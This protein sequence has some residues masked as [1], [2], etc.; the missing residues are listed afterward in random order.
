MGGT[1]VSIKPFFVLAFIIS[2]VFVPVLAATWAE[3]N[4]AKCKNVTVALTF[5]ANE[6]LYLNVTYDSDMLAAMNDL[7]FYDEPCNEGGNELSYD[8]ESI[9][10]SAYGE[11]HI[12]LPSGISPGDII[13][14]Y[15]GYASAGDNTD[16]AD[17]WSNAH[18][19]YYF[20][21][22]SGTNIEDHS[23]NGNNGTLTT[24]G[25]V[26]MASA[27][28]IGKSLNLEPGSYVSIP[29][30][31][32]R[33]D[34]D[35]AVLYFVNLETAGLSQDI[36][37]SCYG[38]SATGR[39]QLTID[40]TNHHDSGVFA[41]TG[42]AGWNR[43]STITH[44]ANNWYQESMYVNSTGN[45]GFL[46]TTQIAL[47]GG[48]ATNTS[49]FSSISSSQVTYINRLWY[50]NSY[51]SRGDF[52]IDSFRIYNSP[53]TA[54]FVNATNLN[55]YNHNTYITFGAEENRPTAI[56]I[57]NIAFPTNSTYYLASINPQY[58]ATSNNNVTFPCYLFLDS[59]LQ[60]TQTATNATL[61]TG[62]SIT[63]QHGQHNFTTTCT[64]S[65][66]NFTSSVIFTTLD[67]RVISETYQ[68]TVY[69]TNSSLF[70][71]QYNTSSRVANI[72]A[73]FSYDDQIDTYY[74][75]PNYSNSSGLWNYNITYT[76][77]VTRMA[78]NTNNSFVW[79]YDVYYTNGTVY[80]DVLGDIHNQTVY[81]AYYLSSVPLS[82]YS[83]LEGDSFTT[84]ATITK[85][86]NNAAFEGWFD[87]D[88]TNTTGTFTTNSSS[89]AIFSKT[90]TAPEVDTLTNYTLLTYANA[91][92]GGITALRSYPQITTMIYPL[93]ITDCMSGTEILT[94]YS[95]NEIND[96]EGPF[97]D[98]E[99]HFI[100]Y[101]GGIAEEFNFTFA[102]NNTYSICTTP[103]WASFDV[104]MEAKYY[105]TTDGY[106]TRNYY[107]QNTT[108]SNSTQN[109]YLYT[110]L[111]TTDT[112]DITFT[113]RNIEN[114]VQSGVLVKTNRY[115]IGE[116]QYRLVA[117]GRSDDYGS[118]I[119]PLYTP[120]TWYQFILEKNGTVLNTYSQLIL[121]STSITL[122]T[123]PTEYL[124]YMDYYDDITYSCTN[125]TVGNSV[126]ISCL[127]SDTSNTVDYFTLE[128]KR[129]FGITN[130]TECTNTLDA[131]SGTLICI[132]TNVTRGAYYSY[133]TATWP[134]NSPAPEVSLWDGWFSSGTTLLFESNAFGLVLTAIIS[135]ALAGTGAMMTGGNPAVAVIFANV[136][137][138]MGVALGLINIGT[139]IGTLI[140]LTLL[141]GVI[142]I[143][144]A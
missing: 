139:G 82:Q 135:L 69:E 11:M 107:F 7:K 28:K 119:I 124:G 15:Y 58:N 16:P 19:I 102:D 35:G 85:E 99:L 100:L 23:G 116:N 109:V 70:T 53:I 93:N 71:I 27:G 38:S 45:N 81:H 117:I 64:D 46:N 84:T 4:Y 50:S 29:N 76:I 37:E 114:I 26:T 54:A 63:I 43:I 31:A 39:I 96:T 123:S 21:E 133:L 104:D 134:A 130:V 101:K 105:N 110:I 24:T 22:T 56:S 132:I 13:S 49:W 33:S 2:A 52:S 41:H 77:P 79:I 143:L 34:T 6:T 60:Q 9:V 121:T 138:F 40:E 51:Y 103:G 73:Q 112:P 14:V 1:K 120:S 127:V 126:T 87:Y 125:S 30:T 66:G 72:T 118:T 106:V 144:V 128:V 88:S 129:A 36:F 57:V 18:V 61:M 142:A 113:V 12:K 25:G 136:G 98:L 80:E 8:D 44:S 91:T 32:F 59:V 131:T 55:I 68:S 10:S 141:V 111:D 67:Y 89:Q 65:A 97:I 75:T 122:Y 17:V 78:N 62:S 115:F 20:E 137:L 83:M 108:L 95:K 47:T 86:L 74:E 5:A 48:S 42:T 94:F 3:S 140:G 92:S 90:L